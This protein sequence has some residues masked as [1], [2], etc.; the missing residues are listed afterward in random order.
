MRFEIEVVLE[1]QGRAV[2]LARQLER[3]D[4]MLTAHSTLN[5]A[6]V[7]AFDM[8]RAHDKD[9][10]PRSDLFGFLLVRRE[11]L[12][13]FTVGQRVD[14]AERGQPKLSP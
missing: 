8:P 14:F 13:K 7:T 9:G 5:G 3:A 12:S 4:F 6:R 1:L 2:V 10:K 11:D